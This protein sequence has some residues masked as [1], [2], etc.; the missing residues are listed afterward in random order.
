MTSQAKPRLILLLGGA[1]S[2]KSAYGEILATQLAGEAPVLYIATA[3]ASDDEMR[4]RIARH[5]ESRPSHWLTVEEPQ[6]PA[7]ALLTTTAPVALLDCVTLLV[8]NHLLAN[9]DDNNNPDEPNFASEAAEESVDH[10]IGD[11]LDAWRARVSTLILISNEVGMGIVPPY[12]LGRVYRDCLGRVNARL[13]AEADTVLL[14]VAGLPIELKALADAWQR[15]ATRR[16][17]MHG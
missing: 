7:S 14:M 4:Q 9:V 12:P 6:N 1:R 11:L 8:A 2:G 5:R 16:F 10:A 15:E 3:T 17:G 13:A